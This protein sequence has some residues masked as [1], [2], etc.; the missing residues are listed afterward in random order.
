[1]EV[2]VEDMEVEVEVEEVYCNGIKIECC[3]DLRWRRTRY[4]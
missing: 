1:M 2:G 4:R 3:I